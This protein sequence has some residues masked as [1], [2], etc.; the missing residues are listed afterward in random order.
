M[1]A[2]GDKRKLEG[3][4]FIAFASGPEK[5][6]TLPTHLSLSKLSCEVLATVSMPRHTPA[7]VT[8]TVAKAVHPV[9]W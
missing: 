9:V 2:A 7:R 5:D 3:L 1:I 6:G 8:G 4:V